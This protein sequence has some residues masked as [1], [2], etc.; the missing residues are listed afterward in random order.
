[1]S[2][3]DYL[4][5]V[6]QAF[7]ANIQLIHHQYSQQPQLQSPDHLSADQFEALSRLLRKGPLQILLFASDKPVFMKLAAQQLSRMAQQLGLMV[8][9]FLPEAMHPL[10]A[11]LSFHGAQESGCTTAVCE[12]LQSLLTAA[13]ACDPAHRWRG[14]VL[15]AA[16]QSWLQRSKPGGAP[17]QDEVEAS[18]IELVRALVK[19]DSAVKVRL[20]RL[21][22]QIS[23]KI[24]KLG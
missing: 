24:A 14:A 22:T 18:L 12:A 3:L 13:T 5:L 16:C 11:M 7:E 15:T 2:S 9:P 1:M 6:D 21:S 8:A 20:Y 23:V 19:W 10:I 4:P 17:M